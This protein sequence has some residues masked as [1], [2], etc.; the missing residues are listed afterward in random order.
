MR[1]VSAIVERRNARLVA[2][3]VFAGLH[4]PHPQRS[5]LIRNLRAQHQLDRR[6]VDNLILRRNRLHVREPLLEI[7]KLVRFTGPRTHQH[8][9]AT[10]H[11]ADHAIDMVMAHPAHAELDG[12]LRL[13]RCGRLH[14]LMHHVLACRASRSTRLRSDRQQASRSNTTQKRPPVQLSNHYSSSFSSRPVYAE[15]KALQRA[16]RLCAGPAQDEDT[17]VVRGPFLARSMLPKSWD[18]R[19]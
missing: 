13:L 18:K 3:K 17:A 7:L 2:Q 1:L 15:C 11:G 10:L 9:A 19:Y 8:S 12:V 4:H 6:V 5:A 16:D 14:Y